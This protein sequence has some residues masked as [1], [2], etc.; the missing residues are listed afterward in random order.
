MAVRCVWVRGRAALNFTRKE[1]SEEYLE[2]GEPVCSPVSASSS[3][4]THL[5]THPV[6]GRHDS[7]GSVSVFISKFISDATGLPLCMS[8]FELESWKECR[9]A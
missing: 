3:E 8:L 6:P 5:L 4:G 9:C 1:G 7:E 2:A